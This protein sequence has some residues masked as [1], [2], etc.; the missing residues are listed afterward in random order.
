MMLAS[1]LEDWLGEMLLIEIWNRGRKELVS[2]KKR[3]AQFL[4][5]QEFHGPTGL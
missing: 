3:R 1:S 2:G 4:K 5:Y